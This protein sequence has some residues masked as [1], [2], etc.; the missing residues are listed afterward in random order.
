MAVARSSSSSCHSTLALR[1]HGRGELIAF[2]IPRGETRETFGRRLRLGDRV[3]DLFLHQVE[4]IVHVPHD[5]T[6]GDEGA[7]RRGGQDARRAASR[8]PRRRSRVRGR[9]SRAGRRDARRE[10]VRAPHP[11]PFKRRQLGFSS[12]SVPR[13]TQRLP[14]ARSVSR[15]PQEDA[16]RTTR[17]PRG[18]HVVDAPFVDRRDSRPLR[19]HARPPRPPRRARVR[20]DPTVV[21]RTADDAK[22]PFETIRL[23]AVESTASESVPH[24]S[25]RA[26]SSAAVRPVEGIPSARARL[27]RLTPPPSPSP[28]STRRPRTSSSS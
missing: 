3:R 17:L 24:T 5:D 13:E 12:A 22:V 9:F 27:P 28:P 26:S 14:T 7:Q 4:G 16:R 6:R 18:F 15:R 19:R 23:S 25:A 11:A 10:S 2:S 1:R 20:P 8:T 21:L